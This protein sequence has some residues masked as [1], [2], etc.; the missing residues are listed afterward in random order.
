MSDVNFVFG[1]SGTSIN[2]ALK[3]NQ[4]YYPAGQQ[5]VYASTLS[6][7][8][9]HLTP[10]LSYTPIRFVSVALEGVTADAA[11]I[12][13][14]GVFSDINSFPGSPVFDSGTFP[15]TAIGFNSKTVSGTIP[16]GISWIGAVMQAGAPQL[17]VIGSLT[18]P[19]PLP[20]GTNLPTPNLEGR[21]G[22]YVL[23]VTGVLTTIT[24]LD[25]MSAQVPRVLIKTAP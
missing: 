6:A 25:G 4:Y 24:T 10:I 12:G 22:V 5:N 3:S 15:V 14:V 16:A 20:Q 1:S 18:P 19:I 7:N 2:P 23:N 21:T 11:G 8:V 17:A 13:R 9:L